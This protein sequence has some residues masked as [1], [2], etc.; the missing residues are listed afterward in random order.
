MYYFYNSWS[1]LQS[2]IT[3]VHSWNGIKFREEFE[4][5]ASYLTTKFKEDILDCLMILCT[6][7]SCICNRYICDDRQTD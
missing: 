2:Q 6:V 3:I 4:H 7:L 5:M 1:I